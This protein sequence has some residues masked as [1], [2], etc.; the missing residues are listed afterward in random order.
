MEIDWGQHS[1]SQKLPRWIHHDMQGTLR[2]WITRAWPPY[3][4]KHG[5]LFK[6]SAK[7][8][9]PKSGNQDGTQWV[10]QHYGS[11]PLVPSEK[12]V[13]KTVQSSEKRKCIHDTPCITLKRISTTWQPLGWSGSNNRQTAR[14][15]VQLYSFVP[16]TTCLEL[17]DAI[18]FELWGAEDIRWPSPMAACLAY[19]AHR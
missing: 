5:W 17:V 7:T 13:I 14:D 6:K 15:Q 10:R 9:S 11:A 2:V 12:H 4:H 19:R 3:A 8:P 16:T 18:R 1:T